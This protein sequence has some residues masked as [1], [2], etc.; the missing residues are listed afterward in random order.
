MYN[1]TSDA[2]GPSTATPRPALR[3]IVH[4]EVRQ[5]ARSTVRNRDMKYAVTQW[6][7][8]SF[9]SL[10]CDADIDPGLW[11]RIPTLAGNIDAIRVTEGARDHEIVPISSC[12]LRVHVYQGAP[13]DSVEEL[14]A[15]DPDS[16][17]GGDVMAATVTELPSSGLEG[18]WESLIYADDV[19]QRLLKYIHTT[20]T[21][22]DALVD[23]NIISCNRVVLLHGPPGTGKTTLCRALAQKLAIRLMSRYSHGKLV[24]INS[25]SLFSK[26]FSESGKLVQRLF[27]MVTEMVEDSHGFVVIL[28]D[29]V[30][31]LTAARA[32]SSSGTEPSDALRVVN[33]VLTQLD[34]LKTRRNVLVMT[35]SNISESIDNAFIDR[36]DIKQYIGPPSEKAIYWIL[37]GCLEEL[38]KRGLVQ[39]TRLL[40][41][42]ACQHQPNGQGLGPSIYYPSAASLSATEDPLKSGSAAVAAAA[43]NGGRDESERSQIASMGLYQLAHD[44]VGISG[45]ALRRLPILAHAHYLAGDEGEWEGGDFED[46]DGEEQRGSAAP[47][48]SAGAGAGG[49]RG[50]PVHLWIEAMRRAVVDSRLQLEGAERGSGSRLA[51]ANGNS[52]IDG[53]GGIAAGAGPM[54]Q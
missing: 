47:G 54:A 9:A 15:G 42:Q 2:A 29:E 4:V 21:F 12:S 45:R 8:A 38:M 35:T 36:A 44:C 22:S 43:A 48:G 32:A 1:G 53:A 50:V 27:S 34:K 33:A 31:S 49:K 13:I 17:E 6:I 51:S 40:D 20:L 41:F 3:Q 28:I 25:H 37:R 23:G 18:V 5:N 46:E 7:Q 39:T 14:A 19:K 26:W 10:E 11:A 52:N 16:E 24:E 30:E